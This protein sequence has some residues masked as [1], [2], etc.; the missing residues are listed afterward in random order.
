ML[1][2]FTSKKNLAIMAFAMLCA[3]ANAQ[4]KSVTLT[5]AGTLSSHFSGNEKDFASTK[6]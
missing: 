2:I 3:T 5:E 4:Q 1:Q 6:D